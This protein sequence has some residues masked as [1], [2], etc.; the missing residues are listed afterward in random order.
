MAISSEQVSVGATS[1]ALHV[2]DSVNWVHVKVHVPTGGTEVFVGGSAVTAGSGYS[3]SA[4]SREEFEVPPG[5]TLSAVTASG[6]STVHVF[7]AF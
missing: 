2:V 1:T 5:E 6:S 7:R 4:G 3:M